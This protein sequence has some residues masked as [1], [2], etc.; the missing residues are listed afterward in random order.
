MPR[1]EETSLGRMG[2]MDSPQDGQNYLAARQSLS[3]ILPIPGL[4]P[5]SAL[6]RQLH[7]KQKTVGNINAIER[8]E[9]VVHDIFPPSSKILQK[10][11]R[12]S[13]LHK[14]YLDKITHNT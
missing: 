9:M 1:C 6:V 12:L 11:A 2:P 4:A 14:R 7:N 5:L 13:A 8:V 10:K 3:C